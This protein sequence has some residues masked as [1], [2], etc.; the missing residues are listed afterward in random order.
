MGEI[1]L[2]NF[3]LCLNVE[4]LARSQEF[5]SKLG[6]ER[7]GGVPEKGWAILR[8]G[9]CTL[10]LYQGHIG[11]NLLNYRGGDVFAIAASLKGAGLTMEMDAVKE[12]DGTDGAMVRDPDG[13]LIYFN[14][15]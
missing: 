6:F 1:D 7:V 9:D 2:G 8:H 11:E 10:G 4:D 15:P 12:A 13:N 3:Q 14:T 5:Y